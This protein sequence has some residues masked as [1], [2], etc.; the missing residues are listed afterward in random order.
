MTHPPYKRH[1]AV[2]D[3]QNICVDLLEFANPFI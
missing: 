2:A 3:K 1:V